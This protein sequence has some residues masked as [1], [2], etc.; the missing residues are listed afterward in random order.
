[1]FSDFSHLNLIHVST[2]EDKLSEHYQ[3]GLLHFNFNYKKY[4]VKRESVHNRQILC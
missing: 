1:M 3:L 4:D 2:L